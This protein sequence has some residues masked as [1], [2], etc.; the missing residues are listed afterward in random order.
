L[1]QAKIQ[2]RAPVAKNYPDL[3]VL[4]SLAPVVLAGEGDIPDKIHRG[5]LRGD[6]YQLPGIDLQSVQLERGD[7][8]LYSLTVAGVLP[9]R[10]GRYRLDLFLSPEQG[11]LFRYPGGEIEVKP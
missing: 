3:S 4:A 7:Q 8:G 6:L 11:K 5:E 1:V 10:A 9:K 2:L